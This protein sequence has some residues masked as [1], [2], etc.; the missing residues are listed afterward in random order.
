V[1]E[2]EWLVATLQRMERQQGE[3]LDTLRVLLKRTSRAGTSGTSEAPSWPAP[4]YMDGRW[5]TWGG[6]GSGWLEWHGA[7]PPPG[8][9]SP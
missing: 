1:S 5:W 4:R 3:I 8:T 9:T 2:S 7:V 6:D